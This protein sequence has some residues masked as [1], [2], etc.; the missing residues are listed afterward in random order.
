MEHWPSNA[1][2]KVLSLAVSW[3]NELNIRSHMCYDHLVGTSLFVGVVGGT[4]KKR[5]AWHSGVFIFSLCIPGGEGGGGG[6]ERS[7]EL[8]AGP[9]FA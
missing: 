3:W 5:L 4:K 8:K 7:W 2:L 6:A 9:W 1:Q